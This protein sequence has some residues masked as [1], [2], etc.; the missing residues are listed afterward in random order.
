MG[1]E[2]VQRSSYLIDQQPLAVTYNRLTTRLVISNG[3]DVLF[4]RL[5]MFAPIRCTAEF[6]VNA[7]H[8]TLK[9]SWLPI[10]S[11]KLMRGADVMVTE[12]FP[13][14][15]RRS[16]IVLGY[17][18]FMLLARASFILFDALTA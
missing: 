17:A 9:L 10:W 12:L 15:R 3:E 18:L 2:W 13:K 16:I 14:R 11:A 6:A 1:F 8:Y 5:V 7:T 4:S